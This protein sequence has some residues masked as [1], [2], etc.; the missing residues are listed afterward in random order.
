[1]IWCRFTMQNIFVLYTVTNIFVALISKYISISIHFLLVFCSVIF[2]LYQ[3]FKS[4]CT[5]VLIIATETFISSVSLTDVITTVITKIKKIKKILPKGCDESWC[6]GRVARSCLW[7]V[8]FAFNAKVNL[9][10]KKKNPRWHDLYT[11]MSSKVARVRPW[12]PHTRSHC[13]SDISWAESP[14]VVGAA[15]VY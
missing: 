14:I 9:K 2:N 3:T 8:S 12:W 4:R 5:L 6:L 11:E 7:V 10:K 13:Y 15:V 1:M